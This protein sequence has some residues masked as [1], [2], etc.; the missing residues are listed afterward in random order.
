MRPTDEE[1]RRMAD[2]NAIREV[3]HR[4]CRAID[5]RQFNDLRSCYH[6][7]GTDHH[8]DFYGGVDAFIAYVEE[9]LPAFESSMHFVGNLHIEVDGDRARSE[10][11]TLALARLPATGDLPERDNT[12]ALRYV[13]DFRRV[14][15]RWAILHRK[16]VYEWTRTD[17][18]PAGWSFTP[19]HLRGRPDRQDTVYAA[20]L[21]DAPVLPEE[22]EFRAL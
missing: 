19:H 1:L 6:P 13:D 7:E 18:V 9:R 2:E 22:P 3:I 20:D 4:Y 17:P 16:C 14:D 21:S 5:R 8:G 15:G 10:A 12:V 11:Y